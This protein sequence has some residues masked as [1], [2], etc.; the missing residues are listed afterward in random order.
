MYQLELDQEQ[1]TGQASLQIIL[2]EEEELMFWEVWR[3]RID[4]R[5]SWIQRS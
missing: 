4:L 5:Y 2:S 3:R 1:V